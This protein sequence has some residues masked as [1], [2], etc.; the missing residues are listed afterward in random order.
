M[1]LI[2]IINQ[3]I[4]EASI[5]SIRPTQNISNAD[6]IK[7]YEKLSA[8]ELQQ[9]HQKGYVPYDLW[10]TFRQFLLDRSIASNGSLNPELTAY[11]PGETIHL[12]NHPIISGWLND[13]KNF[14]VPNEFSKIVF[15]PCAK[16]K[17][18]ENA[19]RGIYKDYNKV[20]KEYPN[21]FFVTISEPLAIVPQT[22]WN[23]FPQYDNPGLFKDTV[24]RS[25]GLF[26]RD[27]KTNFGVDQQ[28]KIPFDESA[29]NTCINILA[30]IIQSF[31]ENNRDK[32]MI[33]FVE[34]FHGISTHSDMLTKAGFTGK[35]LPKRGTARSG[36][37]SHII[38][39]TLPPS[40]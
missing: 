15:V 29:Y 34:D 1:K 9:L 38:K 7:S 39:H 28:Y 12:L 11:T 6:K 13:I 30:S 17:P 40:P 37:Y 4:D 31:I 8:T 33:S 21:L 35:R 2:D 18:W 36:P 19:T 3:G 25:G 26:T 16:T 14:K 10:P 24:Q 22:L 20:R 23:N 5:K 27:F 32:D